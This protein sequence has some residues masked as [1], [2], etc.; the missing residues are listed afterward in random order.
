MGLNASNTRAIVS[1]SS[2]RRNHLA[3]GMAVM[4]CDA[5]S[6]LFYFPV[7]VSMTNIGTNFGLNG[8]N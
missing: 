5:I 2:Y 1:L 4:V 7:Y 6:A 8:L 3:H